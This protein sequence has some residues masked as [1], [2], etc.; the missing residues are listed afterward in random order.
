MA[1]KV[2]HVTS[3]DERGG[4]SKAAA[5]L[6]F[7][8]LGI[9][10]ESQMLV[11]EKSSNAQS[12]LVESNLLL[13]K[14][15]RIFSFMDTIPA[16][17]FKKNIN[18]YSPAIFSSYGLVRR[19]N[20]LNPDI[21]HLHWICNAMLSIEDIAKIK[22]PIVWTLHD[23]WAFSGGCHNMQTCPN[24]DHQNH[25]CGNI[26][27]SIFKRKKKTYL[28]KPDIAIV[29]PS[30]WLYEIAR[31]SELL[32]D[33]QN[34]SIPNP[35]N[36]ESFK[37]MNTNDAKAIWS[38]PI[39]KKI[40][41]CGALNISS[42][43]NKGL[44]FLRDAWN[45]LNDPLL[46]LVIFGND[47]MHANN[48]GFNGAVRFVGKISNEDTL[49]SLYCAADILVVPSKQENFSNTILESLSSGTPV[50]A[51]DVGGNEDLISHKLNGYL[52]EPY[53]IEDLIQGIKLTVYDANLHDMGVRARSKVETFF[54]PAKVA[55]S[56]K[57][58][59][60][61]FLN[62]KPSKQYIQS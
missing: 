32:Q 45:Q 25:N 5:R 39:N 27:N 55:Q 36:I 1:L 4:A 12:I 57:D 59:Y 43:P 2:L 17:I 31:N 62:T 23:N 37:P 51:F 3:Y 22:P 41:V 47:K 61:N 60:L 30:K 54:N 46:E 26:L 34:I 33:K 35:V 7:S 53:D 38:L 20:N 16:R 6:H 48:L 40:I 13:K 11:Q 10:V 56:Y 21:V 29:S 58:M 50:I 42:D 49:N 14:I 28:Q 18:N 9:G 15:N 44:A 52:V 19:I 8:L 24:H